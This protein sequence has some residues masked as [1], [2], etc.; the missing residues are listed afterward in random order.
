M[1]PQNFGYRELLQLVE[2]IESSSH[3]REFRFRSGDLEIELR[4]G[5]ASEAPRLNGAPATLNG[6]PATR[7]AQPAAAPEAA[8]SRPAGAPPAQSA[9][10]PALPAAQHAA[11]PAKAQRNPDAAP[12]EPLEGVV[13]RSPM[14]GTFYRAPEPGAVPFVEVG[15]VVEAETT[16]CIIEVMKLMNSLPAGCRGTVAQ[17]LVADGDAIE[18]GQP[19]IVVRPA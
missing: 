19:L 7:P 13:I 8:S 9:P 10:E 1:P 5:D 6:T 18:Y 2:L 16:V 12:V 11:A 3:F 15:Q 14:V 17:I 4:R